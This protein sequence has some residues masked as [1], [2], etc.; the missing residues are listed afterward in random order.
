MKISDENSAR[1]IGIFRRE[2]A[3]LMNSLTDTFLSLDTAPQEDQRSLLKSAFRDAHS[4]KG[5]AATLGFK[6]IAVIMH[7]LESLLEKISSEGQPITTET[8]D[9]LLAAMDVL[10][11]TL[12]KSQL[13]KDSFNQEENTL[14]QQLTELAQGTR[15]SKPVTRIKPS[16]SLSK[17]TEWQSDRKNLSHFRR[18]SLTHIKSLA[19]LL[20]AIK[21]G[22][23]DDSLGAMDEAHKKISELSD[24]ADSRKHQPVLLASLRLKGEMEEII[25]QRI[26][27]DEA[28]ASRL[29]K[30]LDVVFRAVEKDFNDEVRPTDKG[31]ERSSRLGESHS[32]TIGEK[33]KTD[34]GSATID[35]SSGRDEQPKP[36]AVVKGKDAD[37]T[38]DEFLRISERKLDDVI[39][40]IDEV[41]EASL[42]LSSSCTSLGLLR[43]T[44][45]EIEDQLRVLKDSSQE[46]SQRQPLEQILEKVRGLTIQA[47]AT[48]KKFDLDERQLSKLLNNVQQELRGIRLAPVS[49][50]YVMIKRQMRQLSKVTQKQVEL[51]LEGGEH[52]V[53]RRVLDAIE[54]PINHVLRNAVDHGIED[55]DSRIKSGKNV[56]G[57][58]NIKARHIGDAVELT[59]ADDGSGIDPKA[60]RKRLLQTNALSSEAVQS[61]GPDQLL[62]YVFQPGFSTKAN[63]TQISG[64]GVGMDVVR[65]II[66][67]LGGEVR[68]NSV[69]GE[70]TAVMLRLPLAMSTLRCLLVKAAY[71]IMA[72]PAHNV[73]KV[74]A[75]RPGEILRVAGDD[76][77]VYN[78]QNLPL[79]S[80]AD[81]IGL[82]SE[83]EV[84]RGWS[85]LAVIVVFGERRVAFL[86]DD[87]LEYTQLVLKPLGDFLERAPNLYGISLLGTGELALVLNPGDLVRN[88]T[89]GVADLAQKI[90]RFDEGL[91]QFRKILVVD[92]SIAT[93]TLE[94]TLLEAAG[95][96]VLAVSDGYQALQALSVQQYDVVISD[97]RMPNMDGLELTRTLKAR[98][99]MM[100]IPVIL[101]S[102]M[103]SDQDK[104]DGIAA[105]ADAY[106][107]KKE[108]TQADLLDTI[109]QLL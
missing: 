54:V 42:Q 23:P 38:E 58:L 61:L 59:I 52:A 99:E 32:P 107:V 19:L 44:V 83:A 80:I 79:R 12:Q 18:E 6:R 30:G 4:L 26:P 95:F 11:Q 20:R 75:P 50:I 101:V 36:I 1:I 27:V 108:L 22:S 72:I 41:F 9:L 70:G 3:D 96:E 76:V 39:A 104:R 88:A 2:A 89:F 8:V 49:S 33:P 45:G 102:N 21:T 64:R 17:D 29:I 103:G 74:V 67:G 56:K 78:E 69:L 81:V 43:A 35:V 57:R 65:H 109:H 91:I 85:A 13:E 24:L 25:N 40:Q 63:V 73:E 16:T 37:S 100:H 87:L 48:A 60:I 14:I 51:V 34:A 90:Q 28:I 62:D 97:I 55:A 93:R 66:E 106:I 98:A 68:I 82:T 47:T 92:D 46:G 84:K 53:D 105:G 10:Q 5:A 71:R 7:H 77:L 31:A 86:I 94:K 15:P